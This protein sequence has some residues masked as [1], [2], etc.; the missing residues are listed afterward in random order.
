MS[1]TGLAGVT[2]RDM[3][4]AAGL[5]T[6]CARKYTTDPMSVEFGQFPLVLASSSPMRRM[7]VPMVGAAAGLAGLDGG[8]AEPACDTRQLLLLAFFSMALT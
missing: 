7:T 5:A 1:G 3:G 4:R 8:V 2:L 6:P